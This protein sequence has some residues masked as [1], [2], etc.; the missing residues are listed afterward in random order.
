ME[1][2]QSLQVLY[3]WRY[4]LANVQ[5][6]IY[7]GRAPYFV[8]FIYYIGRGEVRF[9]IV[10]RDNFRNVNTKLPKLGRNVSP[11]IFFLCYLLR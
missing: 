9:K 4:L 6:V 7:A 2:S 3:R 8:M 5:C 1:V 10:L 11:E